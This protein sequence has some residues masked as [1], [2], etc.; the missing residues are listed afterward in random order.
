M[1]L[2]S[3]DLWE[4]APGRVVTWDVRPGRDRAPV[5][6]PLTFNQRNHL[7]GA[8]AGEPSVWIAA[9]FD[10]DGPVDVEALEAAFRELVDRH[11]GLRVEA[12]REDAAG[13]AG[14]VRLVR[15]DA[16]ALVWERYE[17]PATAT[18]AQTREHL[19]AELGRR[20]APF[21][22]PAF[23]PAAISRAGRST[24]VLGMDHLH[25]DAWSTAV[26]VDELA[27]A[28][29]AHTR[30]EVTA[31]AP[32][33]V[34]GADA[35]PRPVP[36][37]VGDDDPRLAAWH[38]FLRGRGWALPTFPLPLGVPDG[39]RL[40]QRTVV[41][42][43]CDAATADAVG[44]RARAA[45]ASTSA[46]VLTT[47]ARAV[48]D[49]GGPATLETLLPVHTRADAAARGSVGWHTTTVPLRIDTEGPAVPARDWAGAVRPRPAVPD[50]ALAATGKA[51]RAARELAAVPLERV[52][53][54]LPEPLR[55]ERVDIFQVSYLDYRR[56]PGYAAAV[57]HDA[58]HVSA[59]TR[60]DDLQLWVTRTDDGLAVRAR[61][62]RTPEATTTVD[63]LLTRWAALLAA[64]PRG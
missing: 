63:A 27:A 34:V 48:R 29:A 15:H 57:R 10:V 8:A 35:V 61:M 32:A 9:A 23:L 36:L 46:A 5:P 56:L 43:L 18:V 42:P 45:G 60:A 59:A 40:P 16:R 12:L 53:E 50:T 49:L 51:L 2:A 14:D 24:V 21:G 55:F 44:A 41:V 4:P 30:Q 7:L 19:V 26:V 3:A 17:G 28:Y 22:Y 11:P 38:G 52:V 58:H 64:L 6:A 33:A 54:S 62:P 31:S 37:R 39:A 1:R 47:L 25:T 13:T 20:C